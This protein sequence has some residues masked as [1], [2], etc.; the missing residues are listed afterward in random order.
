MEKINQTSRSLK[1]VNDENFTSDLAER[2]TQLKNMDK[3]QT[4][5][6]KYTKATTSILDQHAP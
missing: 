2:L 3:L 6:E 4:L 1:Y 5:N